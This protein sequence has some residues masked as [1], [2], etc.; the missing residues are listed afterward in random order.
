M[1]TKNL[2]QKSS[3][4]KEVNVAI[5]HAKDIAIKKVY[6]PEIGSGDKYVSNKPLENEKVKSAIG[7]AKDIAVK[8]IY[9][10]KVSK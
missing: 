5:K 6:I 2:E 9:I 7:W 1:A 10:P 8:K 3:G 4:N